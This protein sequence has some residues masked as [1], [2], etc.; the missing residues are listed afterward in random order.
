V[1]EGSSVDEIQALNADFEANMVPL[2]QMVSSMVSFNPVPAG[3]VQTAIVDFRTGEFIVD[4][5]EHS[6]EIAL[7]GQMH[8]YG[9][10]KAEKLVGTTEPQA[11][12]QVELHDFTFV[13]PDEIRAGNLL[14][15]YHN[16][17]AQWHMQFFLKPGPGATTDAVMAAL[18]TEEEPS[19]PPP[20]EFVSNAGIAPIG[21]GE[22]VWLEF[23]LEPGAYVVGCPV[24]DLTAFTSGAA[25]ISHLAHGMHRILTV[26]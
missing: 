14:W 2:L 15:E 24:P 1:R 16:L 19:G 11:D 20:F 22:R 21:E 9:N 8:I 10:F 4:A 12:V 17:G 18:M 6:G 7:P 3:A 5:I 13:M 23:A 26:K 25:P